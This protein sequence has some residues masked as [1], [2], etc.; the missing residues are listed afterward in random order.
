MLGE[1]IETP[2][3]S[4]LRCARQSSAISNERDVLELLAHSE[5]MESNRLLLEEEYLH[6]AFFDLKTGLA[7]AILQKFA[8]YRV[9]AAIVA[10]LEGIQSTRFQE[11]VRECNRGNQVHFFE[12]MAQA[13]MWLTA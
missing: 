6:P 1:V 10:N 4:Y 2:A 13:E 11:L 3:G 5:S 8:N 7:G 12:D 9:K